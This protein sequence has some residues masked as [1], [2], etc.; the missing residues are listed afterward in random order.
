[1]EI[2][3]KQPS[4]AIFLYMKGAQSFHSQS[5]MFILL[6]FPGLKNKSGKII[7]SLFTCTIPTIYILGWYRLTNLL[8]LNKK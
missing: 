4:L 1:M 7:I 2:H 5:K 6:T 8:A 3:L